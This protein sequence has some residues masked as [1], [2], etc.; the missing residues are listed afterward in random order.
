MKRPRRTPPD[1]AIPMRF[2]Y[3]FSVWVHIVAAAVWIGG[4]FFIV[5]VVVPWLR[6]GGEGATDPGAFLSDTGKRFRAVGWICFALLLVT[7]AFNLWVRGVTLAPLVDPQWWASPLGTA[8]ALKLAVFSVVVVASAVHDFVLGPRATEV[9][10]TDPRSAAATRLRR[11]AS[12]LGRLNGAL[13][14][15]LVALGVVIVRGWPW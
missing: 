6:R 8:V 1:A 7:G 2:L 5:L 4:L 11:Q 14:L 9:M 15:V 12:L 3:L 10:R 13:A